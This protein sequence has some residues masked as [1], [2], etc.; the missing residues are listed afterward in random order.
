MG[1]QSCATE[2][3]FVPLQPLFLVEEITHRV[4]NEYAEA[5]SALAVAARAAPDARTEV[6]LRAAA[7]RL[8]A[9]AEAHRALQSPAAAGLMDLGDYLVELCASLSKA[10]LSQNGV[11]LMVSADEVWL[12]ADRCWRVGLIVAELIRNAARHGFAGGPGSI[13]VE[14]TEAAGKI[15]C[16]VRDDGRG[17]ALGEG[18]RGSRLVQ[19]LANELRGAVDWD[20]T[21]AGCCARLDFARPI[22]CVWIGR[23]PHSEEI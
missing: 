2:G 12:D 9:Q 23:Q 15:S 22:D 10:Q 21:P 7:T 19:A 5:I 17:G 18:G 3:A 20:F 11:R 8:R 1:L 6:T 13:R 14:T 4:L 16:R